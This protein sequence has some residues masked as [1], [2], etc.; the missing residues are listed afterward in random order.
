MDVEYTSF[1]Q[2]YTVLGGSMGAMHAKKILKILELAG[3]T[4]LPVIA[5]LDS[6]GA[7]LG[8]GAGALN[9]FGQVISKLVE[10]SGVIPVIT[11]IGG[12]CAGTAA[13][14]APLRRFSF[15]DKRSKRLVYARRLLHSTNP[16][17]IRIHRQ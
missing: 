9:G 12:T 15:H 2:D 1:S 6:M 14:I 4:G 8:E 13:Y 5:V 17:K 7:R 10:L 11:A 3:K 16:A